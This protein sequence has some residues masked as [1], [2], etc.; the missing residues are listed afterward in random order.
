MLL[1]GGRP[2]S[3]I[4]QIPSTAND[5]THPFF[6]ISKRLQNDNPLP[7]TDLVYISLCIDPCTA[8]DASFH[9]IW[10]STLSP[11]EQTS[12][13]WCVKS[14]TMGKSPLQVNAV[15]IVRHAFYVL[16][17]T[18]LMFIL[19][20][21]KFQQYFY[22]KTHQHKCFKNK[23]PW[24]N[25]ISQQWRGRDCRAGNYKVK[26]TPT[27]LHLPQHFAPCLLLH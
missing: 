9:P 21:W 11:R 20:I 16:L 1:K 25:Q 6:L 4:L 18:N 27:C 8:T 3:M 26:W 15:M 24:T 12:T 23:S 2:W 13:R 10:T 22:K 7:G 5:R 19:S 14:R 17:F